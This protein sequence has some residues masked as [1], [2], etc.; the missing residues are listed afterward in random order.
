MNYQPGNTDNS[1]INQ[2]MKSINSGY[3]NTKN[4]VTESVGNFSTEAAVGIGATSGFLYS[5][6]IIAKFAFI[7]LVLIVFLFLMNLGISII[8]YFTITTEIRA[9]RLKQRRRK[10]QNLWKQHPLSVSFFAW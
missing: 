5:N 8:N 1:N 7:I 3:E 6:T 9:S 10:T 2:L 4:T